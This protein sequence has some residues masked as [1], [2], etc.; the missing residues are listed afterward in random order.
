M[1]AFLTTIPILTALLAGG[2]VEAAT[3]GPVC[4]AACAPRIAQDCGIPGVRGFGKCKK[5]LVR[6]CKRT[7]PEA[8]CTVRPL[9]QPD[10]DGD[11]GGA[12]GGGGSDG[13]GTGGG[14]GGSQDGELAGR[15]ERAIANTLLSVGSTEFFSSG[16]ITETNDM[17][18][19]ASHQLTLVVTTVTSTSIGDISNT[20]DST[21]TFDGTW[22]IEVDGGAATLALAVGEP[23]PRRFA[24]EVDAAGTV[25][26]DGREA[27][28]GDASGACGGGTEPGTPGS[29]AVQ[30][31]T[32][33][34]A[35]HVFVLEE[36]N[37]GF[38]RRTTAILLCSSGRYAIEIDASVF[39]GVE[40]ST[41]G[42]WSVRLEQT[43]PLLELAGEGGEP[44]RTFILAEDADGNLTLNG[45]LAQLGSAGLPAELCPGL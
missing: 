30:Q 27:A 33:A 32:Q 26:L 19:C 24:I 16:T 21:E 37:L 38:G 44:T 15:I 6:A 28:V 45:I 29:D 36:T 4:R 31:I 14:G 34:L 5:K 1:R 22:S 10:D 25:F 18:L 20:F 42:D 35:D 11:G 9:G 7:T 13:G 40:V 8:A 3:P 12:G 39:P 2:P 41:S 23:Q 17:T 43:T